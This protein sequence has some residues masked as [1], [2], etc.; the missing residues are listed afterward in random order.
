MFQYDT[1]ICFTI[2]K[3][4]FVAYTL[5]ICQA[6][7]ISN[8]HHKAVVVNK[9]TRIHKRRGEYRYKNVECKNVCWIETIV[10]KTNSG[11]SSTN[12][13]EEL[14]TLSWIVCCLHLKI[15]FRSCPWGVRGVA[16]FISTDKQL[17]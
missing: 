8:N 7:L 15:E 11:P 14:I 1:S 12:T 3:F 5:L 10:N 16:F 17:Q 6:E 9:A 2:F 4:R 13:N